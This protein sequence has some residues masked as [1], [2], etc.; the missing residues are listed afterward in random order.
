MGNSIQIRPIGFVINDRKTP[1][2]YCWGEVVSEIKLVDLFSVECLD[3]IENFSHLEII[4]HFHLLK[5]ED[6]V[7]DLRH[8][9]NN[10]QYPLTGIFAQRGRARPN[11]L[12]ATIVELV[13]REGRSLFVKGL[14]AID[15]TP[16]VDIKP[17]MK[18]FL[19]RDA[20]KQPEW[21]TDLMKNYWK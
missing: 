13:K 12:G 11:K 19:P 21:S 3:G 17:V 14:D 6:V 2:D 1:E 16:V 15:G 4:F 10:K 8:P 20:V 5:D 9:R 18:E 7:F